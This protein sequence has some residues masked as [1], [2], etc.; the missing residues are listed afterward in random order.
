MMTT[1]EEQPN[2][3]R[4]S[5]CISYYVFHRKGEAFLRGENE[6]EMPT[7]VYIANSDKIVLPGGDCLGL[8]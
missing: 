8:S 2:P 6:L 5:I 7:S 3:S 1:L 4:S